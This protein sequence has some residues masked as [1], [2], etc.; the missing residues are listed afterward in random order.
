[1]RAWIL[2]ECPGP[3]EWAED[4]PDPVAG[5]GEVRVKVVASALN[6]MDLWVTRGLPKPPLPHVPGCDV[7]GWVD[8]V[9]DGVTGVAVGDG[10]SST[11]A[12]RRSRRSS[13]SATTA[14]WAP[15]S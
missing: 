15:A 11:R 4:V 10:S 6:H 13:P 8:Q 2:N 3:Y 12:C 14:R 1:M 5:P 7:A 9:G